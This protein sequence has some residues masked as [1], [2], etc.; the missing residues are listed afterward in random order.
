LLR[1]LRLSVGKAWRA[2]AKVTFCEWGSNPTYSA[3]R[4]LRRIGPILTR[5]ARGSTRFSLRRGRRSGYR[6]SRR[7]SLYRTIFPQ[8]TLWLPE[9]EGAQLRFEFEN[10]IGA[11]RSSLSMPEGGECRLDL[12]LAGS[13]AGKPFVDRP[14]FIGCHLVGGAGEFCFYFKRKL[15]QLLLP[16]LRPGRNLFQ[17][18]LNLTV[19][20][21]LSDPGRRASTMPCCP[22]PRKRSARSSWPGLAR[23]ST[24][25]GTRLAGVPWMPGTRPGKTRG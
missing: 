8:M 10:R 12:L 17:Y 7:V 6:G 11:P 18:S 1:Q 21:V 5:S 4:V 13:F 9:G 25:C 2:A 16:V 14:Q 19:M 20:L 23:P 22:N 3:I 15:S 24:S